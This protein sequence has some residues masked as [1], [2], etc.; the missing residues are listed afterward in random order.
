VSWISPYEKARVV[1]I[2]LGHDEK[3]HLHP[4]L[5]QLVKNA[6]LWAGRRLQ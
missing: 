3:A 1:V 4:G 6:I 2:Q 5:Q